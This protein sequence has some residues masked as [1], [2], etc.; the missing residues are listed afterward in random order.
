MI[1]Q[2]YIYIYIHMYYTY[3]DGIGTLRSLPLKTLLR[4]LARQTVIVSLWHL[5]YHRV[6]NVL[7][8]RKP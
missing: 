6:H 3:T 1:K 2:A 8:T 7:E 4:G 5:T